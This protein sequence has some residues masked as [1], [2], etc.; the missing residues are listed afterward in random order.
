[1]INPANNLTR[2]YIR[3]FLII[4]V[5]IFIP[6]KNFSQS[7]YGLEGEWSWEDLI[8]KVV[9]INPSLMRTVDKLR[10]EIPVEDAR[11][12]LKELSLL[13]TLQGLG[14][15]NLIPEID[16]E[17]S[18]RERDSVMKSEFEK[19]SLSSGSGLEELLLYLEKATELRNRYIKDSR[20]EFRDRTYLPQPVKESGGNIDI[21]FDFSRAKD[22]LDFYKGNPVT[23]EYQIDPGTVL[24]DTAQGNQIIYL[25]RKS[26]ENDPLILIYKWINP[27]YIQNFGGVF[28]YRDRFGKVISTVEENERNIK[29]DIEKSIFKYLPEGIKLDVNLI[30]IFGESENVLKTGKNN[31]YIS[32]ENFGD[33]YTYLVSYL[34]HEI[35][36]FA[37]NKIQLGAEDIITGE[38]DAKFISLIS[39]IQENGMANFVGPVGTETRPWDLLEKDFQLFNQTSEHILKNKSKV[40]TDSLINAGFSGNAPFYTMA[41]QMAYI[42]ETTLGSKSL[43]ES[44][45]LGPVSFFNRY[46]TAYNEYSDKIRRVFTFSKNVEQQIKELKSM[47]PEKILTEALKIN[48]GQESAEMKLTETGTFIER[49][50]KKG[51]QE[52]LYYLSGKIMMEAG[53]FEK[54]ESYF[55]DAL[56][57]LK[58]PGIIPGKTGT[59]FLNRGALKEA[60]NFFDYFVYNSPGN[61]KA[62]ELRGEYY[63]RNNEA[64]AAAEDFKKA[65]TLNPESK[66]SGKYLHI[67]G[68][69]TE[70]STHR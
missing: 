41:T 45:S 69:N 22:V 46:I 10:K 24:N 57:L 44:V 12:V 6:E 55:M 23:P 1:M 30:F 9:M 39:K 27:D 36:K 20:F 19:L 7:E 59:D 13:N 40:L 60:K 48:S 54:S 35:Y 31:I 16:K 37:E 56:K 15:L 18:D 62:Y 47:L 68:E 4:S 65:I 51:S 26:S 5:L 21:N 3:I 64:A 42:I 70:N 49:N 32:M 58:N 14:E 28:I 29:S 17:N 67:L 43:T 11:F 52:L 33:N 25:L 50:R 63:Y 53:D 2:A 38:T 66:I 61:Y 8:D 34:I